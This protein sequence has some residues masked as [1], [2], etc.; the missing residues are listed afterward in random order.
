MAD[1]AVNL[2]FLGVTSYLVGRDVLSYV[3]SLPRT[4]SK[5]F[6]GVEEPTATLPMDD[7]CDPAAL[8]PRTSH[9]S[10][11]PSSVRREVK[12]CCEGLFE[13]K[14]VEEAV[15]G[16]VPTVAT[17]PRVTCLNDL[18][19]GTSATQRV[20][21]K[22]ICKYLQLEGVLF[23]DANA[24]SD[25]YRMVIVI[26]HECYGSVCTWGQYV[27]GTAGN[28]V[29]SLPSMETVGKGRRFTT[30]VDKLIPINND[31]GTVNGAAKLQA[32]SLKVPLNF[33]TH[34]SGNAGTISDIVKN[35]LCVIEG[36]Q[37]G[38]VQSRWIARVVFLDG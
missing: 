20:G 24:A 3:P 9:R 27:Q 8:P 23:L 5:R 22:I 12:A 33:S 2:A 4:S 25:Y 29:Y 17:A 18:G 6:R 21:N 11:L 7:A 28:A 1:A 15:S 10:S 26:D 32:F 14:Y 19:Q 35:S 37:G 13:T 31:V 16:V 34:Y 30:L 38:V 36:S